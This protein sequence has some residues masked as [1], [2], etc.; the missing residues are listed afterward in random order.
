[1]KEPLATAGEPYLLER[2]EKTDLATK[3][4]MWKHSRSLP[5]CA[6]DGLTV[7]PCC[8]Q[9]LV[10]HG[11]SQTDAAPSRAL[12]TNRSDEVGV[13]RAVRRQSDAKEV[14]GWGGK[15]VEADAGLYVSIGAC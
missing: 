7:G 10:Q 3:M 6:D 15:V 8:D 5:K 14:A 12:A 2:D 4:G 1:M 9:Q 11:T 13:A